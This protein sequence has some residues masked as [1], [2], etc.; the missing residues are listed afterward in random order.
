MSDTKYIYV[1]EEVCQKAMDKYHEDLIDSLI[2]DKE[3]RKPRGFPIGCFA[4][5]IIPVLKGGQ[6]VGQTCQYGYSVFNP[7]DPFDKRTARVT[8][9]YRML[10]DCRAAY[11][12]PNW[13]PNDLIAQVL[14]DTANTEIHQWALA[15][16]GG[17]QPLSLRFRRA[18]ARMAE[19]L[20]SAPKSEARKVA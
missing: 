1:R 14:R 15:E 16:D 8:A 9:E 6:I 11:S 4:Y 5:R 12:T 13:H 7:N 3:V 20:S 17:R 10:L 19:Q 2:E 18:C